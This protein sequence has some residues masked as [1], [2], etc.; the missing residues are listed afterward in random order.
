VVKQ[1][2]ERPAAHPPNYLMLF[3]DYSHFLS[4]QSSVASNKLYPPYSNFR[5]FS[6]L[7][8]PCI[9]HIEE[10]NIEPGLLTFS[11]AVTSGL[12]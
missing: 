12:A 1:L 6:E 10:A 5:S 2:N 7:Q 4:A 9:L 3:W 11:D 8:R